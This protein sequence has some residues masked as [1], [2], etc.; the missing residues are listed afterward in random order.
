MPVITGFD[1]LA[2]VPE[3]KLPT[4]SGVVWYLANKAQWSTGA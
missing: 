1:Q 4:K 2:L 3:S